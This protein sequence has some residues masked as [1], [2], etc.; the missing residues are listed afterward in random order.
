ML[1]GEVQPDSG[2]IDIGETVRFRYYSQDGLQFDDQLKVIDVVQ[3]IAEVIELG[4]GKKL[5]AS[6]SFNISY[7]LPKPSTAMCI[8]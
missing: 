4:N 1:M 3:N 2:T 7:L 8:S 5:T 6:Q